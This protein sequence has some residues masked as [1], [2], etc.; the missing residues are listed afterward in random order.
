MAKKNIHKVT[1]ENTKINENIKA[2]G[3]YE[4]KISLRGELGFEVH[5][6]F[7]IQPVCL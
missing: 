3:E 7:I 1:D 2:T 6:M 5:N 4:N